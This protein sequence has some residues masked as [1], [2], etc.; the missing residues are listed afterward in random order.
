MIK[1][2]TGYSN[3]GGSTIALKNLCE[4][5]SKRDIECEMYGP[6]EWHTKFGDNY[7]QMSE[8]AI[9]DQ[10]K[11]IA[12][13]V[14]LP[15]RVKDQTIF[16]CHEMWWFDFEKTDD[17]Y[18]KV[19]FLTPKQAEYH[20][21]VSSHVLIPNVKE[22]IKVSK[23]DGHEKVAAIIGSI[24]KRKDTVQSI[25]R[26]LN[27]GYEQ[28]HL[29]GPVMD[30]QYFTE[31]VLSFLGKGVVYKGYADKSDIYSNVGRVY[32]SSN[33]EVASLVKDECYTTGTEFFGNETTDN[34]VSDLSND[35]V[36]NLWMRELEC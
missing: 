6:H 10:D 31:Q 35:D 19:Q 7:K 28:I 32:H 15:V 33:G 14:N 16:S 20:S 18:K 11:V 24:E 3:P 12:H 8:I 4:E 9:T 17:F 2:V 30:D 25:Q 23:V 13:F 21:S 5:F 27:D 26:A 29:Y 34:E 36:I 1:I 22:E